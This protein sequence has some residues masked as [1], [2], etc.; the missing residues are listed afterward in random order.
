MLFYIAYYCFCILYCFHILFFLLFCIVFVYTLF[1]SSFVSVRYSTPSYGTDAPSLASTDTTREAK[2][3]E[4]QGRDYHFV[5]NRMQ[6]QHDVQAGLFVE[7][8]EY[9]GNLY[10]TSLKAV[11]EV[12][13]MVSCCLCLFFVW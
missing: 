8:G 1:F 9:N 7:A 6:M 10:G 12:A 4:V 11:Q 2:E 3:D 5:T 13:K